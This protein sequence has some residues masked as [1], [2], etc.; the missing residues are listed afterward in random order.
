MHPVLCT[1]TYHGVIDLVNHGMVKN[2]T[3][4]RSYRFL[5]EVTFK[6]RFGDPNKQSKFYICLIISPLFVVP[7]KHAAEFLVIASVKCKIH[8]LLCLYSCK[9]IR[10]TS[11][12]WVA[13]GILNTGVR[14]SSYRHTNYWLL[15]MSFTFCAYLAIFA[16]FLNALQKFFIFKIF[17]FFN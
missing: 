4:L 9:S 10:T 5:A 15:K 8:I 3:F 7:T 13:I 1:N 17:T 12:D 16:T 14:L 2:D 11:L 6:N